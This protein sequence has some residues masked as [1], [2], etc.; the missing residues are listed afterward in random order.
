MICAP[1]G[2][3]LDDLVV[4]RQGEQEFMVVA[5]AANTAT[6]LAELRSRAA[7]FE[8]TVTDETGEVA[9][10]AIQGPAAA[11]ILAPLTGLDVGAMKY[12]AGA[13]GDVAGFPAFLARTGYTGEDG[14]EVFCR[15][16]GCPAIWAALSSPAPGRPGPGRPGR[17]RYAAAQGRHALVRQ[18]A[19]PGHDA[20]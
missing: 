10:I 18:R 17:P 5:N 2:G 20:V 4:Y 3:V 13:S 7:G 1:D 15:P 14:F 16:G 6:V 19:R 11:G 12:Y 9:L 8:A